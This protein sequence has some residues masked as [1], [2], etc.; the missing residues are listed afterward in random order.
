MSGR[1]P[2]AIELPASPA[3]LAVFWASWCAPCRDE[4]PDLARLAKDPPTG[5]TVLAFSQDTD[6]ETARTF[7]DRIGANALTTRMD[8]GGTIATEFGVRTLP[9]AVLVV[10]GEMK[11]RFDGAR[12]WTDPPMRSL[13]ALLSTAPSGFSR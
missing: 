7:L 10:N 4:L 13:L 1:A 12:K 6:S 5:L 3:V 9:G 2:A 8:P 11:A